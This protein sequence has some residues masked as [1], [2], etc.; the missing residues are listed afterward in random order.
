M[1]AVVRCVAMLSLC[2]GPLAAQDNSS[3]AVI[4]GRL[5]GADG[6]PMSV[7]H[8]HL[9]RAATTGVI[10]EGAVASDG[11]YG[12]ATTQRG[13]FSLQ[14]TGVDHASTSVPLLLTGPATILIDVLLA[15][16][17]YADTIDK[18]LAIGDWN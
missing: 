6:K 4:S 5:L 10:T 18:V 11:S 13:A 16:Y 12:L 7:A 15:R 8:V 9:T 17:K 14:F 3:V 2:A 1:N